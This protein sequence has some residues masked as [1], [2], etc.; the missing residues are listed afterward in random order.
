M[1]KRIFV[2]LTIMTALVCLFA[3]CASADSINPST[4][5]EFGTLTTFDDEI[6]NTGISPNKADKTIAR[7][8]LHDG[9]GKYYT[10]PTIYILTE[11]PKGSA[12]EMFYLSFDEISA[13]IGFTVSKSSIIRS[14][15][16]QDIAYI[17]NNEKESYA[18]CENV[19]EIIIS[20]GLRIWDNSQRKVFQ[21]C[22]ALEFI[23]ISKMVLTGTNNTYSMFEYCDSLEKVI[24]PDAYEADGAFVDYNTN[25]MFNGCQSLET[26][27]NLEGLFK[28]T[29]VIKEKMFVNCNALKEVTLWD[30]LLGIDSKTFSSCS[31]LTTI[32]IPDTVTYI[33][34][35]GGSV[36][37]SCTSLKTIVM[38]QNITY[39]SNYCFEKCTALEKVWM[40]AP[41]I[42]D[43]ELKLTMSNQVF[44]QA[45]K[46]GVD[47]YLMCT[48]EEM[49][50]YIDQSAYT[51]D[52]DTDAWKNGDFI[53][54]A[55]L[56]DKC[57]IFLG[58][59]E[60]P[61]TLN[62]CTSGGNCVVCATAL[63]GIATGHNLV[64][65]VTFDNGF[66]QVGVKKTTCQNW[67]KCTI[68]NVSEEL[69]PIFEAKGYSYKEG[70]VKSGLSGGFKVNPDSLKE[71]KDYNP[72][73]NMV[74]TLLIV[75]PAYL[76]ENGFFGENGI[77][78][79]S[80][81]V[82]QVDISAL[83]YENYEY[84]IS[85]FDLELMQ[86]LEL[87]FAMVVCD[88][89]YLEVI[90]KQYGEGE[91]SVAKATYTDQSEI[92]LYSVTVESVAPDM[93][94]SLKSKED[95]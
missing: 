20:D 45:K 50:T 75:N 44:G 74:V 43:P 22:K 79:A 36:F 48:E 88:G 12:G 42:E 28:G 56:S 81:G 58:G 41:W 84:I 61:T 69:A 10:V 62:S 37:D 55:T 94:A 26:I 40:P 95:E 13:K 87:A 16:P 85:G 11:S 59:H 7:T 70:A 34:N 46:S 47:F 49:A 60:K 67:E 52:N 53:Y 31:S 24:L 8:V 65:I 30:G 89:E 35:S 38:S 39:L 76:D 57:T 71:Y 25:Y 73:S 21:N 5:N 80:K 72:N 64:T 86:S 1:K 9:N 90:Q 54:G 66:A 14:E 91:T 6:G 27:E 18:G 83:T 2:F 15:M 78:T 68:N 77:S 82:V 92:S 93:V 3:I 32:I 33:G 23:D 4:S 19:V 17:C 63:E 51:S 29:T